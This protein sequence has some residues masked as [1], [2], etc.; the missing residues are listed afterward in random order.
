MSRSTGHKKNQKGPLPSQGLLT[1]IRAT[2]TPLKFRAQLHAAG[3]P[4]SV[5]IAPDFD[6]LAASYLW[7]NG[8]FG[9]GSLSRSEATWWC[10]EL[11]RARLYAFIEAEAKSAAELSPGLSVKNLAPEDITFLRR[12][13]RKLR[14]RMRLGGDANTSP[15][16]SDSN[17]SSG[18]TGSGSGSGSGPPPPLH[19]P[20]VIR[21]ELLHRAMEVVHLTSE[22]TLFLQWALAVLQVYRLDRSLVSTPAL[23]GTLLRANQG[24]PLDPDNP[25]LVRYAA[26]HYYRSRGWVIRSGLK[27]ACDYVLYKQGPAYQH[28]LFT[29]LVVPVRSASPSPTALSSAPALAPTA[30]ATLTPASLPASSSTANPSPHSTSSSQLSWEQIITANR[31]SSQ[32]QKKVIICYVT[33][34]PLRDSSPMSMDDMASVL[35]QYR[36]TE[37]QVERWIPERTR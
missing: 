23:W 24:D 33:I 31:L 30:T 9:K 19:L 1:L 8:C 28:S 17:Y 7:S 10:R 3:G 14:K 27:F 16:D 32:A 13:S 20:P 2:P 15:T 4:V 21:P 25:F 18:P 36:M 34:P 5:T 11:N 12:R 29:V 37:L 26:Y 6:P 35:N 22:E